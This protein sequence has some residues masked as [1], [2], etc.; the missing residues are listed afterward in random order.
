MAHLQLPVC[1]CI[2]ALIM[3]SLD[4]RGCPQDRNSEFPGLAAPGQPSLA[5]ISV[6][7]RCH[8]HVPL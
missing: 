5:E 6:V 7:A 4:N 2:H 8:T 1:A 3:A